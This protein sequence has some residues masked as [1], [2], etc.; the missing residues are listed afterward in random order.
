MI[1]GTILITL[2]NKGISGLSRQSRNYGHQSFGT[3][4]SDYLPTKREIFKTYVNK[5]SFVHTDYVSAIH[6]RI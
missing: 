4:G 1:K 5:A 2:D 6:T 3:Q